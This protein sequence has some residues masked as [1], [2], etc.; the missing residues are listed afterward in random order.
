LLA[1]GA[2]HRVH[3]EHL[4]GYA[5]DRN[6]DEGIWPDRKRGGMAHVEHALLGAYERTQQ[7]PTVL[8]SCFPLAGYF[9]LY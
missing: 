8:Q 9:D 4:P 1:A 3:V 6:P 5:P 7:K 2:A